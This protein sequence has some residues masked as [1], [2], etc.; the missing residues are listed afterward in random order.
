MGIKMKY[1]VFC[2]GKLSHYFLS[3]TLLFIY[4]VSHAA[5]TVSSVSINVE[6]YNTFTLKLLNDDITTNKFLTFPKIIFTKGTKTF[7]VEGFFDGD[8]N[9][10]ASG[11]IWKTRFMPD[12]EGLWDYT[13]TFGLD[14]GSDS[15]SVTARSN[16]KNHGHVS[17]SGRYL[18]TSDGKSFI[19]H[20]SNWPQTMQLRPTESANSK[21]F[22]SDS[23]WVNYINRLAETN[24]NGTYLMGLDRPLNNDRASFD[25]NWLNKI[26]TAVEVAAN[27][28]I[29]VILGIFDTWGR[30]ATDP[31]GTS[32]PS[33]GQ[34]LDP[35]NSSNLMEEKEFYLRYI[36]ARYAGFYNIFWELGNEMGHSNDGG[37]F[38]AAANNYY[39][40]W[41]KQYDPYNLP[42]TLSEGLWRN[43]D[44][45]IGGF[46]QNQAINLDESF[47]IIHTELVSGGAPS[48]MWKTSTY[49][50]PNNRHYYREAFWKSIAEGGSGSI[51]GSSLSSASYFA[52]MTEFLNNA[53]IKNVMED[54]G[55][56]AVFLLLLD[57]E[58]NS[59]S[60][61]GTSGLG[62]S[63]TSYKYR[64]NNNSEYLAYFYGAGSAMT[65]S[66]T[67]P[68]G[69]YTITW[70]SPS[71]GLTSTQ[72]VSNNS[73][74]TSP[75]SNEYDVAIYIT[76]VNAQTAPSPPSAENLLIN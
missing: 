21:L 6:L 58:L 35:W 14:S 7:T 13:W 46:H 31:Y 19:Y 25:L 27:S 69:N 29:Y 22:I 51:E 52:T 38:T 55:R 17:R 11:N 53:A 4:S 76:A 39:I 65:L 67:L 63:N 30:D 68:P 8:E 2:F 62:T 73:A 72:T 54:H 42:M 75:W 60:P 33:S 66:L 26:D 16:T 61:K 18:K 10:S 37:K 70:Y 15:F 44:V 9:G 1:K 71:T 12:E 34:I 57:S 5:T 59:F 28:G 43:T 45:E 40:P 36:V 48:A 41:I 20:G 3:I 49:A 56:L 24:H 64:R 23:D 50:D 47:P 74:V 32:I